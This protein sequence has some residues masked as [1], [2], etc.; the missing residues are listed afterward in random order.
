M[1]LLVGIDTLI[2]AKGKSVV[3]FDLKNAKPDDAT[4]RAY[5][6]GPTGN[7]RAPTARVGRTLLVGFNES[8][9]SLFNT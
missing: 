5:L 7:L 4:I 6:L 3:E 9:Y 2:V 1:Q 8:S